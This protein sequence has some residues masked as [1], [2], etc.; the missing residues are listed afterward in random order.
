[1]IA[2]LLLLATGSGLA[3]AVHALLHHRAGLAGLALAVAAWLIARI[4]SRTLHT[5]CAPHPGKH[6]GRPAPAET[7]ALEVAA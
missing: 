5:L 4:P 6:T 7:T 3:E 2:Y 1:M